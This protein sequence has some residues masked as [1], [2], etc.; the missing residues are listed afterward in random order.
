MATQQSLNLRKSKLNQSVTIDPFSKLCQV[1]TMDSN[2]VKIIG[3]EGSM[4]YILGLRSIAKDV[5]FEEVP[6]IAKAVY[7]EVVWRFGGSNKENVS[8]NSN[9]VD[10]NVLA[11]FEEA[12]INNFD[13]QKET[14]ID[15]LSAKLN[16]Y[17]EKLKHL[18]SVIE[19]IQ[20][21]QTNQTEETPK[22]TKDDEIEH[23]IT[24]IETIKNELTERGNL[25]IRLCEELESDRLDNKLM[26]EELESEFNIIQ[27]QFEALE[28]SSKEQVSTQ[29][30]E[31]IDFFVESFKNDMKNLKTEIE[32]DR[33]TNETFVK[34]K[35]E[36]IK[37]RLDTDLEDLDDRVTKI[38][39]D[40]AGKF[41]IISEK[42]ENEGVQIQ[43][44]VKKLEHKIEESSIIN[45]SNNTHDVG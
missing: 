44:Q 25:Y 6:N 32:Q 38:N 22:T 29:I 19:N 23:I 3:D 14:Q 18:E 21:Q 31:N 28:K 10:I 37:K 33:D 43:T 20:T 41:Q 2:R 36:D 15:P 45:K 40:L 24:D 26:K 35:I 30:N 34:R 12:I 39:K 1:H 17:Q 8:A 9:A 13:H 16:E 5:F 42:L 11:Q 7:E 4:H 27:Q